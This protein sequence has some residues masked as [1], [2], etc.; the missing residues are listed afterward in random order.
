MFS[1]PPRPF[2]LRRCRLRL[3]AIDRLPK[4][5]LFASDKVFR[6]LRLSES[7][8]EAALHK[9]PAIQLDAAAGF[10]KPNAPSLRPYGGYSPFKTAQLVPLLPAP[11]RTFSETFS[12]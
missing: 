7:W 1:G 8:V 6:F 11:Y 4:S 3:Y 10:P 2:L 9:T 12:Y 5:L